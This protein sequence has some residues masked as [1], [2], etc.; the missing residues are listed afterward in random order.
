MAIIFLFP[1][2]GFAFSVTAQ[3][4]R[5]Q[6]SINDYLG[7]KV[8]FD[9]GEGEVDTSPITDFQIVSRSSS[10][11]VSIINGSYSKTVTLSFQL[12]PRAKGRLAIPALNVSYDGKTYQ[13]R[14]IEVMVSDSPV[15]SED[16]R[17]IFVQ[18]ELSHDKLF[19]GQQG[20]YRFQLFSAVQFSNA[21][22]QKPE[23]E[24]FSVEEMGEPHEF[25]RNINGRRYRGV[26]ISYLIIPRTPGRLTIAPSFLSCDV[27]VQ[28]RTRRR[29]P[30]GDSFFP[31]GFF[32]M[33]R[34]QPRRFS[35]KAMPLEVMPLP[36]ADE[37]VPFSGL[38]G[39]FSLA[40]SLDNNAIKAGESATLTVTLSGTGNVM[41][42]K[43]PELTLPDSFKIYED[44]PVE[45][46]QLTPKG[47]QGSKTFKRA[48]VPVSPGT[49]T[50]PALDVS[51]F[52]VA[53]NAYKTLTSPSMTLT[54]AP[55]AAL[56]QPLVAAATAP[57][58]DKAVTPRQVA[59]TGR[60]ILELKEGPGLLTTRFS[61]PFSLFI[62]LYLLPFALFFL[63]QVVFRMMNKG[64]D[65]VMLLGKKADDYL[66]KSEIS[67]EDDQGFLRNLYMAMMCRILWAA[68]QPERSLTIEEACEILNKKGAASE[69]VNQVEDVMY[70]IESTRYGKGT[71]DH[72]ARKA[73]V[74]RV[75]A[76]MKLLCLVLMFGML[77]GVSPAW[78]NAQPRE[79][80]DP[81]QGTTHG[82]T[83][84]EGISAYKQGRFKAAAETFVH[85]ASQGMENGELYYN[86]GNAFLK[87]GDIGRAILWYER[88]K[89]LMPHD[90][91]LRFN[92]THAKT[93]VQDKSDAPGIDIT[94]ML[95]FWK[96]YLPPWLMIWTAIALSATFAVYAGVRTRRKK[97]VFTLAGI[98][99]FVAVILAGTTVCYDYY[100]QDNGR[101]AVILS[102]EAA[103]HSGLSPDSTTLFVLHAGTR[104]RVEEKRDGYLKI[105]FSRD[106][107]GWVG[108][109]DAEM[110]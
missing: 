32:P 88:A 68:R 29:D 24:E 81:G 16:N 36:A 87:A 9:G 19:V 55:G 23:F 34:T 45:D 98:V 41:D 99:F 83:L 90:P 108:T 103:I 85:L 47:Y 69:T 96:N 109:G 48:L 110:I 71:L 50:L 31:N 94:G 28:D 62:L 107:I 42:A 66:K 101:F 30:F 77:T 72:H 35:T 17:D 11:N 43:M 79:V 89:T 40:A 61:M 73:L 44:S 27:V 2:H 70:D 59:F 63:V 67:H 100:E 18:A 51:Y 21:R 84:L 46:I 5:N 58:A 56:E 14:P 6:I 13:T 76:I 93:F 82:T 15:A 75:K 60:D 7:L 80:K 1:V 33:G 52:D 39:E 49:F 95:F 53:D 78:V 105:I 3:V 26:E 97:R 37:T 20:I 4:D 74:S 92:L 38:V 8:I 12:L 106:K 25:T 91:D 86:A 65:P 57:P 22:L 104:V 102:K 54:V 64:A 10:S